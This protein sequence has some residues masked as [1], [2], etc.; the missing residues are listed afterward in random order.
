MRIIIGAVIAT[1]GV[2]FM[3]SSLCMLPL[4]I[5]NI[6]F[7]PIFIIGIAAVILGALYASGL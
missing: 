6:L 3:S 2:V 7:V 5:S 4:R 1:F